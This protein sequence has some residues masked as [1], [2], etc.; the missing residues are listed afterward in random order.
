MS[1]Q[2]IPRNLSFL[3]LV[4]LPLLACGGE[5]N[6]DEDFVHVELSTVGVDSYSGAPV[7]LLRDPESGDVV[8]IFIGIAEA[9]AIL[10][11]L[12]EVEMPRPMTHDLMGSILTELD[13][14]LERIVVH[15]LQDGTYYGRIELRVGDDDNG[16]RTIDTRPSDGFALAVRTGARIEVAREIL[17]TEMEF[18]FRAPEG[19]ENVV[20]AAG[21]T[22]VEAATDLLE[23]MALPT[24]KGGVLISA[25]EPE[26]AAAGLE[27]GFLVLEVNGETVNSPMDF[28]DAIRATPSGEEA[29]ILV[30]DQ[31]DTQSIRVPTDVPERDDEEME[32]L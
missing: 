29:E 6:T 13:A 3:A 9:E 32:T 4:L 2:H 25:V 31:E 28:L 18:D 8:P 5:G 27:P 10:R 19:D 17:Q 15:D 21:I 7:A 22:V 1:L 14:D 30:R 23:E 16:H 24:D 20:Q 11:A 12:H 26:A